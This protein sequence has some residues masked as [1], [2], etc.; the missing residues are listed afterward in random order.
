MMAAQSVAVA[1]QNILLMAHTEGLGACWMCAPLFCPDVVR[2]ALSLPADWEAQA[3]ITVG[4][5]AEQ[6]EKD[7]EPLESKTR[8][9]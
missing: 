4:F 1:A 2:A 3:L 7:R 6:R 8:W 5:P 9:Y